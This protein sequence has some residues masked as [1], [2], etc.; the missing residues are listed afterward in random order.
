M[1]KYSYYEKTHLN[2]VIKKL[3][4]GKKYKK[5]EYETMLRF[6]HIK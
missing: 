6:F 2:S 1:E 3:D 5:N 4:S